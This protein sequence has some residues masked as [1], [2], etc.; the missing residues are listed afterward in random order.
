VFGASRAAVSV[1]AWAV[2][3][4]VK[5]QPVSS[6][7][8]VC[9][10]VD[11]GDAELRLEEL[12]GHEEAAVIEL[13]IASLVFEGVSPLVAVI[14]P[15][16][17]VSLDTPW[18]SDLDESDSVAELHSLDERVSVATDNAVAT[19]TEASHGDHGCIEVLFD[20]HI[21]EVCGS[22][23]GVLN[24]HTRGSSDCVESFLWIA[25]YKSLV[26]AMELGESLLIERTPDGFISSNVG[27]EGSACSSLHRESIIDSDSHWHHECIHVDGV[28]AVVADT[29]L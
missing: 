22:D 29:F 8:L 9:V 16:T 2:C 5:L 25:T 21:P 11:P 18:V 15:G 28:N 26:A 23:P 7:H 1:R 17:L 13:F 12:N 4:V 6:P 3:V 27:V 24:H 10:I 20:K 14:T 19:G